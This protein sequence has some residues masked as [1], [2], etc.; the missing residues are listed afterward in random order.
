[1]RAA[2]LA[3]TLSARNIKVKVCTET[4]IRM[5]TH[6]DIENTDVQT[7]LQTIAEIVNR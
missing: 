4:T 7:V 5:V 6:N 1:M 2:D 3:D